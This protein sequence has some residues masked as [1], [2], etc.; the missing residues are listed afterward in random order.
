MRGN[1]GESMKNWTKFNRFLHIFGWVL[2]LVQVGATGFFLYHLFKI[3]ILPKDYMILI[4]AMLVLLC[5]A[6]F[7]CQHWKVVGIITK[8]ISIVISA[9][10]IFGTIRYIKPTSDT[11][12]KSAGQTTVQYTY[13]VYILKDKDYKTIND[14]QNFEF[15][16]LDDAHAKEAITLISEEVNQGI[17][18]KEF[19]S[20][21]DLCEALYTE[22]S[23][24]VVMNTAVVE[25]VIAAHSDNGSTEE[26][27]SENTSSEANTEE[28]AAETGSEEQSSQDESAADTETTGI[29]GEIKEK[30]GTFKEDTVCIKQ[31]TIT[32][33][34]EA[35]EY[36]SGKEVLTL[37]VSGI[38]VEGSPAEN[39]NSDVNIIIKIN[40]RTKQILMV[41][42][43][44]DYYVPTTESVAHNGIPDKLTHAGCYGVE[45]SIG[46]LE[47]LYDTKIDYYIKINFSGFVEVI[48]QLGG[49][50]VDSPFD[51]TT[52][53]GGDHIVKGM[54]HLTG[55]QALG[56]ARERY[57][58][59]DGDR[60]RG[61]NHMIIITAMLEKLM[62][63]DVL[64][65]YSE[66]LDALSDSM[67]TSMPKEAIAD[68]VKFQLDEMPKWNIMSY[69]VDGSGDTLPSYS[70][71]A[72]Y[73]MIPDQTT[74]DRAKSYLRDMDNNI[75]ISVVAPETTGSN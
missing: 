26:A 2:A 15:G 39:R 74:V 70:L 65:N 40:K 7:I 24:V 61:R 28:T 18:S 3:N 44:R 33:E 21:M 38:D 52:F 13:G 10:L 9:A 17:L 64:K 56:F 55:I 62:S 41:S 30:Y 1:Y 16:Y 53:H 50:D 20:A 31:Y 48:D 43:P 25:T 58:F 49:I 75:S 54:N 8:I 71:S 32:E 19:S 11:L 68:F 47:M 14:V 42:T 60:Q 37:Y 51:F 72:N 12:E 34:V 46:T 27:S 22:K 23:K 6:V 57:S 5:G 66:I 36:E 69:S 59:G 45:C 35:V 67:V 4:C 63:A 29:N 73:V